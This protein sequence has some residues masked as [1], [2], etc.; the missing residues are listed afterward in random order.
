MQSLV[1]EWQLKCFSLRGHYGSGLIRINVLD[2]GGERK[3][4]YETLENS[5]GVCVGPGG[6][7]VGSRAALKHHWPQMVPPCKEKSP[8]EQRPSREAGSP[9]FKTQNSY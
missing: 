2:R 9:H 7:V 4:E 1:I 5:S 3:N 6:S 8:P